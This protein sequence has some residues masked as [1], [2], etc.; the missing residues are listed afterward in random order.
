MAE[1]LGPWKSNRLKSKYRSERYF[2]FDRTDFPAIS[3][4]SK[5][6]TPTARR[7]CVVDLITVCI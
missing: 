4:F 7:I 2:G 6:L 1:F 5:S 3:R